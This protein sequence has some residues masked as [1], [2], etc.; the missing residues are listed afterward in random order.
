MWVEKRGWEGSGPLGSKV[1]IIIGLCLV[2]AL[3]FTVLFLVKQLRRTER[4][5]E[6]LEYGEPED[7]EE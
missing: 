1:M 3:L 7:E 6:E 2:G 5:I 4:L